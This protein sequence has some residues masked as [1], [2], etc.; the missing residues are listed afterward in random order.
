MGRRRMLKKY[1]HQLKPLNAA[2]K[3][4]GTAYGEHEDEIRKIQ[5]RIHRRP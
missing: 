5:K 1:G 4:L 3:C 2:I